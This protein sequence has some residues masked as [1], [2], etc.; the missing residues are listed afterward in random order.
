MKILNDSPFLSFNSRKLFGRTKSLVREN[1]GQK[2][3]RFIL[4][5]G[6]RQMLYTNAIYQ[7]NVAFPHSYK[8]WGDGFFS[9]EVIHEGE[10]HIRNGNRLFRISEQFFI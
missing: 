9:I 5:H 10:L 3:I 2:T 1:I 6:V 4:P 7:V 8:R